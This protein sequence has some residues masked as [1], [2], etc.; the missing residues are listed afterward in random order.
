MLAGRFALVFG[1]VPALALGYLA[2]R[3]LW[4]LDRHGPGLARLGERRGRQVLFAAPLLVTAGWLAF[5]AAR[6]W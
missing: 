5:F 3:V 2:F 6:A 1:L 4:V